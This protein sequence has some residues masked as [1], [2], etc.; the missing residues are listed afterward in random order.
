MVILDEINK[1]CLVCCDVGLLRD[2]VLLVLL[3]TLLSF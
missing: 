2:V 1:V 3:L